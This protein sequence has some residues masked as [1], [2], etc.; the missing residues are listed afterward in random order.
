MQVSQVTA[1]QLVEMM[2]GGEVFAT[3]ETRPL[4]QVLRWGG[5]DLLVTV[6]PITGDGV[7]VSPCS[8]DADSGG[9]VHDHARQEF[10][11]A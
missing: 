10:A 2:A 9:S 7:V 4:V 8:E 6:C 5:V 3:L 1:D 11:T